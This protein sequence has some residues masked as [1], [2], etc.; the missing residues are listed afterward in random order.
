MDIKITLTSEQLAK[1][2]TVVFD[3]CEGADWACSYDDH[4]FDPRKAETY[5]APFMWTIQHEDP[6]GDEGE[7]E[8]ITEI[9]AEAVAK[10]LALAV[11][12]PLLMA[13]LLGEI[14]NGSIYQ[15]IAGD[16]LLQLIVFGEVIFG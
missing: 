1:I 2:F 15:D 6:D 9:N 12:N 4:G 16:A 5:N 11:R 14:D 8:A 10:G 7:F 3:S 13:R